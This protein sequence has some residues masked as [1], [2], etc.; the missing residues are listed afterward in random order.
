[1]RENSKKIKIEFINITSVVFIYY[2]IQTELEQMT[3]T[4]LYESFLARFF[5]SMG[6]LQVCWNI[7]RKIN[8]ISVEDV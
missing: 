3:S 5:F 1:M 2:I 8:V 4:Q 6:V 7:V